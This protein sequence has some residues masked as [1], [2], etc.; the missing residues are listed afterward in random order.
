M[1]GCAMVQ[2]SKKLKCLKGELVKWNREIFGR[3]EVEIRRLEDRI[4]WLEEEVARNF[5]V[6]V[7][8]ELLH[9]K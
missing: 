1:E 2:I 5:S 4:L 8:D 7:E 3:V 6:Q 9:S